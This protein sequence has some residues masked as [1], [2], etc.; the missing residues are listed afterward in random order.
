[1]SFDLDGTYDSGTNRLTGTFSA[2]FAPSNEPY[3]YEA[4]VSGHFDMELI[5]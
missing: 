4:S 2:E 1:M 3:E 5:Q